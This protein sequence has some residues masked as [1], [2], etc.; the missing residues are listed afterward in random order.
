MAGPRRPVAGR[1]RG[2]VPKPH[3]RGGGNRKTRRR[4]TLRAGATSGIRRN[5]A[6]PPLLLADLRSS[7]KTRPPHRHPCRQR[8]PACPDIG[9]LAVAFHPGLRAPN[10]GVRGAAAQPDGGG[11]VQPL[12]GAEGRAAG[13]RRD[14]A[15]GLSLARHQ[16]LARAARGNAMVHPVP[17]RSCAETCAPDRAAVRCTRRGRGGTHRRAHRRRSYAIIRHRFS[18]P[19][20]R[21]DRR[22]APGLPADLIRKM[23]IDNPMETYPRLK[24]TLP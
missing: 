19:S 4:S 3:L 5:A 13:V 9:R 22:P 10:H 12:S 23:A 6:R 2:A 17:R 15:P 8:L 18:A 16:I 14:L 1:D 24:E 11:R 7:R 21:G 20:L